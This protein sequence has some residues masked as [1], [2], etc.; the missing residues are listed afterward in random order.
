MNSMKSRLVRASALTWLLVIPGLAGAQ[1]DRAI[2]MAARQRQAAQLE[3]RITPR[4]PGGQP[5]LSGSWNSQDKIWSDLNPSADAKGNICY[6][7]C[8][9]VAAAAKATAALNNLDRTV[10]GA[11]PHGNFPDYRPEARARVAALQKDLNGT[12]PYLHNCANPGLPRIGP[13]SYI[14]QTPRAVV[15]L[16]DNVN[17]NYWR[18]VSLDGRP[19]NA[20]ADPSPLGD[21]VGHWEG[22][23]LVVE[24]VN[25]TPDTWLT[26][27]GAIHTAD[28][29]VVERF[30]RKGDA[31]IYQAM[32]YDPAVLAKPWQATGHIL[33]PAPGKLQPAAECIEKDMSKMVNEAYHP[34]PP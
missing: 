7:D 29:R 13:P 9:P 3:S 34:N 6:T 16:Y 2:M 26:D 11:T 14:A 33:T 25:F 24:T 17:G 31:I 12:D 15:F 27:Y 1:G 20:D 18:I 21:S 19:H 30:T 8:D 10:A 28:L 4:L 5:D 23:T 22:D 32:A